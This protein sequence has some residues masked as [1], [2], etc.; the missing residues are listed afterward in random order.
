MATIRDPE[1]YPEKLRFTLEQ[2]TINEI[3][4]VVGSAAYKEHKYPSDVDVYEPVTVNMNR[5]EAVK[6]YA[7][8]FKNIFKKIMI[9]DKLFYADFKLGFDPR[10]D[11]TMQPNILERRKVALDYLEKGL[12]DESVYL[13][14]YK[15]DQEQFLEIIR[16][17]RILRW[18]PDEVIAGRKVLRGNVF[19]SIEDALQQD[20]LIKLDVIT[21]II[22]RYLSIEV[23]FNLQYK[24]NN[25]IFT[26]HQLPSYIETILR[27][28]EF[29]SK[30][31][32]Y[33]PLKVMKRLWSLSRI[34]S[35]TDLINE[36]NPLLKSDAAA[37]NQIISDIEV[38]NLL[39]NLSNSVGQKLSD[40]VIKKI[41]LEI[42][43]FKK[44]IANHMP[45]IEYISRKIDEIGNLYREIGLEINGE[46]LKSLNVIASILK[47][48]I[49]EKS[50]AFLKRLDQLNI[51]CKNPA[52]LNI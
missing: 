52:F 35:C 23:F 33:N 10:F 5:N 7:S 50:D 29:Y 32:H 22:N 8:Q 39:L 13:N 6:F 47:V 49:I 41:F 2:V 45:E 19:I 26:F 16:R 48:E 38:L 17:Q 12:I 9:N 51:T 28:I 11:L 34:K 36:L 27:D 24:E 1:S 25:Q 30:E 14:L 42:L 4:K 21:W 44:R 31:E 3:P 43:G 20:T 15:A 37:L 46:L 40:E 18:T